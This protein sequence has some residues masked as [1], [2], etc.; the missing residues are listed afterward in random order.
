VIVNDNKVCPCCRNELAEKTQE[1]DEDEDD[2]YTE[3]IGSEDS[4]ESDESDESNDSTYDMFYTENAELGNSWASIETIEERFIKRGYSL[5]DALIL[6]TERTS[7]TNT[8]FTSDYTYKLTKEF[9]K[10]MM[11]VDIETNETNQMDAE[12]K[13]SHELRTQTQ[14]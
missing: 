8:R 4:D 10:L 2:D 13:S 14:T 6:L 1:D 12:D 5:T 3:T 7:N 9:Q 11:E